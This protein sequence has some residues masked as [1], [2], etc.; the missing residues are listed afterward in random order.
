M[1]VRLFLG[2]DLSTQQLK[3]LV[4]D[5]DLNVVTE[6]AVHF[7]NDLP[8][9]KTQGGVHKHED[10][11]TVTV[12]T[13]IWV[14]AF[15]LVLQ[16]L[17]EKGLKFESVACLSGT[18]Q[19][20]GSIYW[21]KGAQQTLRNL[22]GGRSLFE[23]LEE[24][25]AITDSPIWM[26]SSTGTQC[27]ALEDALGGPQNL[28]NITGSRAYERFTGNQIAK[29]YQT[30]SEAF[31]VCERISLVSSFAAS[32]FIGDYAP[33]DF[34]DGSGM[35]LM[36][37]H[38]NTWENKCLEAC[39]PNLKEKLGEVVP[40]YN[41]IGTISQYMILEYGFDP[42]CKVVAFTGDNPASLAGMRLQEGDIAVSLGTSDTLMMCFKTPKPALEG[43]IFVNPVEENAYMGLLCF[44]NGSLT[45]E[46]IRNMSAD[47]SWEQFEKALK[48]SNPGNNGNIGIY[49]QVTEITPFAVG[50]HR[51]DEKG[52]KI[53]SFPKHV[54]IRALVEG[55]FMAKRA[56]AEALG[57]SLGANT[58]ILAT[59]GASSNVAILQVLADVFNA[60][61]YTIKGTANSAC[62]GCAYRAKHGLERETSGASFKDVVSNAPHYSLVAQPRG[63]ASNIYN[64]QTK[65]YKELEDSIATDCK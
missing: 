18:G 32:L 34:S 63:D 22:Q 43:H 26:D 47:G 57:Y 61:V 29:M 31:H 39:A 50:V 58:S 25:F 16:R 41:I 10:S 4:I 49:F 20:H 21:K 52:E 19:Q 56:H 37:I 9:F 8:E 2:F 53:E 55:Q 17:K 59:G 38:T 28:S 48:E 42:G 36:D 1:V 65:R 44:K 6:A 14:R 15:D 54:E 33:I 46:S 62:L 13:L 3:A 12:P 11:L 7:D 23:Q 30:K 35:N 27:Q 40:S 64:C 5:Q 51:F 24:S 60:P 45:R